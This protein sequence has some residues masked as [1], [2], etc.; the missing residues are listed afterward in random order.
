MKTFYNRLHLW[1]GNLSVS[2]FPRFSFSFAFLVF[3]FPLWTCFFEFSLLFLLILKLFNGFRQVVHFILIDALSGVSFSRMNK[4]DFNIERITFIRVK[5]KPMSS[6][7][8]GAVI[9]FVPFSQLIPRRQSKSIWNKKTLAWSW[10]KHYVSFIIVSRI[11]S[12]K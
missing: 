6:L 8:M 12:H 1:N 11:T 3:R 9:S 5:F 7:L 4:N 10:N 2:W